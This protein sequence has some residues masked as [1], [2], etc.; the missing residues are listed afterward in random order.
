[1]HEWS[2]CTLNSCT[3]K[4]SIIGGA[5]MVKP[6]CKC[7]EELVPGHMDMPPPQLVGVEIAGMG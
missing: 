3:S 1:M 2:G 4:E 5:N 6:V 7:T